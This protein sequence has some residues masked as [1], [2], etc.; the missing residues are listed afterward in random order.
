VTRDVMMA[1]AREPEPP[2]TRTAIA[3][4]LAGRH[5]NPH[6]IL[7]PHQTADGVVVRAMHPEA[8][9]AD[10]VLED[11][12]VVPMHQ[13]EEGL[14]VATLENGRLPLAYRLRFHFAD[15]RMWER[16]DPYRFGPTLG[17]L[18][19]HLF[20]E[21]MH[22]RLWEKLGAHVT[23]LDGVRGVSFA[24]WAPNAQRV[25]V[26]GDFCA[27]DGRVF[28]MRRVGDGGVFELFVPE[29]GDGALYKFELV[30]REGMIRLKT[31]PI[32]SKL[33]Q[34][35]LSAS[36]VVDSTYEWEDSDWMQARPLRDPPHEPVNIY[37]CHLG[38]WRRMLEDGNRSLTYREIAEPLAR[39][40]KE[41]G[42]THVELLPVAEHP[43][44]GSWGYQ[45]SGYFAP[46]SRYGAPDDFRYL[47]DVLHRAGIGVILDWVPAH[48]PKDDWALR[49]FDGTAMY[50]HEDPQQ[51]EH[52]EWGTLIFNYGRTEVRNFLLANALY[53][54]DE[55]HVDALRV[56]AVSS[57][58]FLDYQRPEGQWTPNRFGGRENLEAV[59]FLRLFNEVIRT[60]HPGCF[61]IAEEA[62]TFPGVT[63]PVSE[64]GLGFTF[65]WNMGWMHDTLD[66]LEREPVHR[67]WH[68]ND[69][70]FAI[71]Y[72][73][74][75][76]FIMPLSH[77][78]VVHLK[79]SLLEKFPGDEWQQLATL[80]LLLAYQF[81]RP[82]KQLLFMG[83]ELAPY[84]EWNHD[85]SLPWH[86]ANDPR[87]E[88]LTRYIRE[89][90]AVYLG[91][92]AF[93]RHDHE[94]EG[95]R[96]LVVDDRDNSVLAYE[97]RDGDE[98]RVI[99]LNFTPDP[100]VDYRVG[101][102]IAGTYAMLLSS[103]DE[104]FYGSGIVGAPTVDTQPEPS[105]GMPQSLMLT[106]PPLGALILAPVPPPEQREA[107][108][109]AKATKRTTASKSPTATKEPKVSKETKA[110]ESPQSPK[111]P[112]SPKARKTRKT[113]TPPAT[114]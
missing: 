63:R 46:T 81:S 57:M 5:T 69:L 95:F 7:G 15:G 29:L 87:R 54:L 25:S 103:D 20:H 98:S 64:G 27:W 93:W 112:K 8:L 102:P 47:V 65:K 67:R 45:V 74:S 30:T 37:E 85:V 1:P 4:L 62:S 11:G 114:D 99:V 71:M 48:F 23:E 105:H 100:R 9:R 56:D 94:P 14:F 41:L 111:S 44:Y 80:R 59:S 83:T 32:A 90:G 86:L 16:D 104:R 52:P 96:W 28:P 21:G 34:A 36:I 75:E 88:A 43:F 70:T 61:T 55:F 40:V 110:P 33:Q 107:A 24:V 12:T 109:A 72:E 50:E 42:F 77:D 39:H 73:Y 18:D 89:L 3:R 76:R 10:V 84:E 79:R 2:P 17:E 108:R 35:P 92:S 6:D 22:L 106:L 78:E 58:L 51:A 91:S 101:V 113:P 53:W 68:H 38:S 19:V 82:G 66:Y 31:D 97:R 49:R 60:T 26:V 13:D